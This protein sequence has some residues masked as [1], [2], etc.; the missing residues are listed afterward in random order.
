M[1]HRTLAALTRTRT[2]IR[3]RQQG[4]TLIELLVVVLII[5]VLA[6]VAI[7]IFLN[8][9]EG[10]KD[11]AVK[12]QITQAKTAVVAE[13][14]TNTFPASLAAASAYTESKEVTVTLTGSAA[15][16]CISG[17]YT[18]STRTFAID[19]NGAAVQGTCSTAFVAVATTP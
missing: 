11:S 7:P 5:G 14:V 1:I 10:A 3:D 19:D 13:M 16:F 8:Q 18:G 15:A 17:K 6:A 12:A 2:A 9:Q 4:F